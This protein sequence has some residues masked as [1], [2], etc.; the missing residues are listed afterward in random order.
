MLVIS[1]LV[2]GRLLFLHKNQVQLVRLPPQSLAEWYKP[3]N[4]RHVWLHNMFNLRRD[5]QAIE[6]YAERK[7]PD[8]LATW[9]SRLSDH[10]ETIGEMV[11]EWKSRLDVDIIKRLL[12]AQQA[13]QYDAIAPLLDE[14]KN[15]CSACHD[16]FRVV[17]AAIY[18]APDF[19][20]LTLNQSDT[21]Q[22]SMINLNSRIN[23]IKL[24]S[25]EDN[26]DEALA[27]FNQLS[28]AMEELGGLCKSCH[29]YIP[30]TYLNDNVTTA[31]HDLQLSLKSGSVKQQGEDLGRLAVTACAQCHG[32]HRISYDLKNL[33]S[34]KPGLAEILQH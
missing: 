31:M 15:N 18:R 14:L 20:K 3:D 7:Q 27:V 19:K 26:R 1:W 32:S 29:E 13:K 10:Y 16:Q 11:P 5:L 2:A 21:L 25:Q 28:V 30:K 9:S 34:G 33:L 4:K 23:Q 17:T 24:A 22:Q 6:R 8:L 12:N